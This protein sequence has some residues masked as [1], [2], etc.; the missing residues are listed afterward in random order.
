MQQSTIKKHGAL[1]KV[2][3]AY[4]ESKLFKKRQAWKD[5]SCPYE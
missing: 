3:K 4:Q 5:N 1:L 2:D